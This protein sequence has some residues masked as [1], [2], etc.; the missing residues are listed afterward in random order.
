[1]EPQSRR[2]FLRSTAL[3]IAGLGVG[4]GLLAACGGDEEE[5]PAEEAVQPAATE[6][7]PAAAAEEGPIKV[8]L[9]NSLSGG[10]SIIEK[11]IHDAAV[12]AID[13]INAAGGV[14]GREIQAIEEDYASDFTLA[15]QKAEKLTQQDKVAVTF[16]CY[17]SASRVSVLP[18]FERNDAILIYSTFYEGLECS[19]NCFYIAA[20]PTQ[21]LFDFTPWVVKTFGK[22]VYIVGS[23]YIYPRTMSAIEQ[24]LIEENGGETVDDRYFPLGTTEFAPVIASFR[25]TKPDV[26]LSNMVG[27]SIPA[28]Y[29]Q[30]SAAGFTA[31][32]LPI[33]AT[34]TTEQEVQAMGP[35]NGLG[36][37]MSASYFQ[38]LDN[39]AN[40]KFVESFKGKYGGD[41]VT[42]MPMT[43]M[44]DAV[45]LWKLA[46][47]KAGGD[48]SV[49]ALQQNMP[50][51][52]FP[53]APEGVEVKVVSNHH[54]T[55]PALIGKANDQGQYDVVE[56]FGVRDPDPF[57]PQ[58]VP[59]EKI[60]TCP[61]PLSETQQG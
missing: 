26:I 8:G 2:Q 30:F 29:K 58:I 21:Q 41:A 16:G 49:A 23:D 34:V 31:D 32:T 37:Y 5:A 14:N 53:D 1:M 36:H 17:T 35:E 56:D 18:V 28:M 9:L 13:E 4:G 60:P 59:E 51:T 10:L 22:R 46:V 47:E 3:G 44:Y 11:S 52:V 27:D 54:V 57:P 33:A 38:S 50:G 19:P 6:T 39:P 42:N 45:Y 40:K 24:I 15:V 55:L 43:G 25:E 61:A 20:V 48:T 12:L 7:A